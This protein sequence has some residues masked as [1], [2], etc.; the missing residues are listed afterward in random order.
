MKHINNPTNKFNLIDIHKTTLN[1]HL[2][3]THL[4]YLQKLTTYQALKQFPVSFK[5]S[6]SY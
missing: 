1:T 4:E 5:A 3:E 2:S 6:V